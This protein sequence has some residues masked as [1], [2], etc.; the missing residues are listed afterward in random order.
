MILFTFLIESKHEDDEGGGFFS[1]VA[2]AKA[3]V[4]VE[5]DSTV[6]KM[7]NKEFQNEVRTNH[8]PRLRCGSSAT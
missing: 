6:A 8:E 4:D 3:E 5:L 1:R 2:S 7:M